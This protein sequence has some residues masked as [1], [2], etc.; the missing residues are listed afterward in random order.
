MAE[1]KKAKLRF[2]AAL[3]TEIREQAQDS[4]GH[5]HFA[6]LLT[7]YVESYEPPY[8]I[9]ILGPWG[10][11]KSSIKSLYERGL[12]ESKSR[13]R[14][15]RTISFNAWR[16]GGENLKRALIA[17]V[18]TELGGDREALEDALFRQINR[19]VDETIG[20]AEILKK[21]GLRLLWAA[22]QLFMVAVLTYGTV[23]L[24]ISSE[25]IEG[26]TQKAAIVTVILAVFGGLSKFFLQ[27]NFDPKEWVRNITKID[28]PFTGIEQYQSL[29]LDKIDSLPKEWNR[30]VIFV[31][32]LDRLPQEEMVQGIE[33]IRAFLEL[34]SRNNQDYGIIFVISCDED[35]VAEA[36]RERLGS[37][38]ETKL[39]RR[40]AKA[41]LDRIFQ[42]RI[43]VP[44]PPKLDM[45][46]FA[47]EKLD[48]IAPNLKG[49]LASSGSN[50]ETIVERLIHSEVKNPRAALQ[51]I[52]SFY[53]SWCLAGIR[54]TET[55]GEEAGGL[56]VGAV[57][58][59]PVSLAALTTL[60]VNFPDFYADLQIY[61]RL[62]KEFETIFIH[63]QVGK[64][65]SETVFNLLSEYGK[66]SREDS[67]H[68]LHKESYPLRMII[69]SFGGIRWPKSIQP[70]LL[71][72]QNPLTRKLGD[73]APFIFE[74][75]VNSDASSLLE[76][77]GRHLDEGE[78]DEHQVYLVQATF[79]DI[80]QNENEIRKDNAVSTLTKVYGR[81]PKEAKRDT[82][83]RLARRLT[84]SRNLRWRIGIS[85]IGEIL[86]ACDTKE[87]AP[88]AESLS[89]DYF[90]PNEELL[91][92]F[93]ESPSLTEGKQ[94]L[95]QATELLLTIATVVPLQNSTQENL[96]NW[97]RNR[98]K[99]IQSGQFSFSYTEFEVWTNKYERA[100]LGIIGSAYV[101]MLS[102]HLRQVDATVP[103]IELAFTR[104]EGSLKDQIEAGEES[105]R[106]AGLTLESLAGSPVPGAREFA[107]RFFAEQ[108][109]AIQSPQFGQRFLDSH[110][111]AIHE[112]EV[113]HEELLEFEALVRTEFVDSSGG[114]NL[115]ILAIELCTYENWVTISIKIASAFLE[116]NNPNLETIV[117]D[118]TDRLTDDL[119]E[120]AIGWLA[121]SYSQLENS[122][123]E[124]V[125]DTLNDG[126]NAAS[127]TVTP[128]AYATFFQNLPSEHYS[129][130][131]LKEH[132]HTVV[133]HLGNKN[134]KNWSKFREAVFPQIRV[135]I[136]LEDND[137]FLATNINSFLDCF[138]NNAEALGFAHQ[139]LKDVWNLLPV[140]EIAGKDIF[141]AAANVFES[142]ANHTLSPIVLESLYSMLTNGFV[143][144]S[145]AS[146][147][148]ALACDIWPYHSE[149][150]VTF[151]VKAT[152]LRL[153][154]EE[155]A[156]LANSV[157]TEEEAKSL[158]LV[159]RNYAETSDVDYRKDVLT[160]LTQEEPRTLGERR[161]FVLTLWF[162]EN[163]LKS[164]SEFGSWFSSSTAEDAERAR[165]LLHW[166]SSEI[167]Q[168]LKVV[169]AILENPKHENTVRSLFEH[170][171]RIK[172]KELEVKDQLARK[173]LAAIPN[174][175]SLALKKEATLW[176][177]GLDLG[178]TV[179]R[180][181]KGLSLTDEEKA[182][183]KNHLGL[184][185]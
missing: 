84:N 127:T 73:K 26:D 124:R 15:T 5:H 126:V 83:T 31:D 156:S 50:L 75:L 141:Q 170:R 183:L 136:N 85:V 118:W 27:D 129:D 119:S 35:K 71:L 8:S 88:F 144:K 114:K 6:Q 180:M 97:L 174:L 68:Q 117:E 39:S 147:L 90:G 130:S 66:V 110:A 139:Y 49:E 87:W 112:I 64:G 152:K 69:S 58:N 89:E 146:K 56:S 45:R 86:Q 159:W 43:E 42:F 113:D 181:T 92:T 16:F 101:E 166:I 18:Y 30:L 142:A 121:S 95:S 102:E 143:E 82:A 122:L 125:V 155:L 40:E 21:F 59:H 10:V 25:F 132:A 81:F 160:E 11:G 61:P 100:V 12:E 7:E 38:T 151:L 131:K 47:F 161:D 99:T 36:L 67:Q 17:H 80:I 135:L 28:L 104:A 78:L 19:S 184:K 96:K 168:P 37:S 175:N 94:M 48:S 116:R 44:P 98:T 46:K 123:Q 29:L 128:L 157:E 171:E 65:L 108:A 107:R 185:I 1:Q 115:T 32:D 154:P 70:L 150:L 106:E 173:L 105:R 77:L 140:K 172:I 176:I 167:D 120:P 22:S 55:R 76:V 149:V 109:Q 63:K 169:S 62:I 13:S 9:G 153:S 54:E 134:V 137:D 51:T 52:N 145:Q 20:K 33:A 178:K 23:Q 3:D 4:F 60:K 93:Q 111:L 164:D 163:G 24:F 162:Q 72:S 53:Q 74:S 165:V 133:T 41:Y 57:R 138:A 158:R 14:D 2:A 177:R 103:N 148:A 91:T 34:N 179:S 79:R 182:L